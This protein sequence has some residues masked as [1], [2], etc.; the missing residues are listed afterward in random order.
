[1]APPG[2]PP[3]LVSQLNSAINDAARAPAMRKR[4]EEEGATTFKGDASDFAKSLKEEFGSW[5]SVT[6]A[7]NL[8]ID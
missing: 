8:F 1:V 3:A 5:R 4:F 2:V 7:G 6:Q